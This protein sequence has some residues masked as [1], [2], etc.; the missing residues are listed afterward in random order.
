MAAA[1]QHE[2]QWRRSMAAAARSNEAAYH[3]IEK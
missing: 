1:Q 2:N 3:I